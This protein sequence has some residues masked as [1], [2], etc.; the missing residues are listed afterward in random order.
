MT[1]AGRVADQQL[2]AHAEVGEQRVVV[3]EGSQRYF[4]RRSRAG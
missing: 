2:A 3:V 4:P 1:A